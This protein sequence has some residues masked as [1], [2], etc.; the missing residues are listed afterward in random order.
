[1]QNI[2]ALQEMSQ[3]AVE[4]GEDAASWSTISIGMCRSDVSLAVC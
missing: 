1:M 3:L 2:L 4:S